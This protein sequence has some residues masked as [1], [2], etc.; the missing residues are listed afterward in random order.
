MPEKL[1]F[2][3]SVPTPE[4]DIREFGLVIRTV[5][6]HGHGYQSFTYTVQV[7][8]S[9]SPQAIS[10]P[11]PHEGQ[12]TGVHQPKPGNASAIGYSDSLWNLVEC[13]RDEDA[14]LRP[15]IAEVA[16]QLERAA[17]E[18]GAVMPHYAQVDSEE[19]SVTHCEFGIS[20]PP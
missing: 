19:N 1:G 9:G 12:G 15:T 14:K 6:E 10:M 13:C 5:C 17:A 18:W 4:T 2:L 16:S 20:I 11:L 7:L 8:E 3:E